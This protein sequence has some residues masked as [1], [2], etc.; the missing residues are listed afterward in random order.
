MSSVFWLG[1]ACVLG[2]EAGR[3]TTQNIQRTGHCTLNLPLDSMQDAVNAIARTTG[4]DP[5]PEGKAQRGYTHLKD[6]FGA[7]RLTPL[8]SS[9]VGAPCIKECPVVME[10]Q[11]VDTYT[12]FQGDPFHGFLRWWRCASSMSR[13]TGS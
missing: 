13:S 5:V 1:H 2:L 9:V 10:A 11:L 7:A 4:S 12:M 6:K 3:Q 8:P